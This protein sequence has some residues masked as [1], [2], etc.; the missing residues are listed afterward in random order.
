MEERKE[1]IE[2]VIKDVKKIENE[3][4][5]ELNDDGVNVMKLKEKD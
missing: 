2:D 3:V 1:K 5:K 4:K